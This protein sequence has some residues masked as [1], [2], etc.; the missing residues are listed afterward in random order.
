MKEVTA[1]HDLHLP[2]QT[3]PRH[4]FVDA[5]FLMKR[6]GRQSSAF[7]AYIRRIDGFPRQVAPGSWRLDHILAIEDAIAA[8][9]V[10]IRPGTP[11]KKPAVAAEDEPDLEDFMHPKVA[12]KA[13]AKAATS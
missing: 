7:Y 10:T 8:G 6:W 4:V 12:K 5:K 3:D 9:T 2:T 13:K 11:K 1:I